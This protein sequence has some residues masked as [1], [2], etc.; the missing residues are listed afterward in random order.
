MN[1]L[2]NFSKILG[3]SP[4]N[5]DKDFNKYEFDKKIYIN[6]KKYNFYFRKYLNDNKSKIPNYEII[7]KI[8][9]KLKS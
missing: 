3:I 1:S 2:I 5:I 4:L 6:D 7:S 9:Y 8:L